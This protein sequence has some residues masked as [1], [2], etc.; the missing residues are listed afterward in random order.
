MLNFNGAGLAVGGVPRNGHEREGPAPTAKEREKLD[1]V[2][3]TAKF[4]AVELSGGSRRQKPKNLLFLFHFQRSIASQARGAIPR[5]GSS[6]G[7]GLAFV[8]RGE[9]RNGQ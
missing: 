3:I 2:L 4:V 7:H 8:I 9:L 6:L 1:V 5:V